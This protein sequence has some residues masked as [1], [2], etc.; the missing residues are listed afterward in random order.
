M[1]ASSRR[2]VNLNDHPSSPSQLQRRTGRNGQQFYGRY[3]H[4]LNEKHP[5]H[6]YGRPAYFASAPEKPM[7]SR[8]VVARALSSFYLQPLAAVKN[9][10]TTSNISPLY[11]PKPQGFFDIQPK[12]PPL[13][14]HFLQTYL[15]LSPKIMKTSPL[16]LHIYQQISPKYQ[17]YLQKHQK[18]M[19]IFPLYLHFTKTSPLY[20][21][22]CCLRIS[23]ELKWQP[24]A[25]L[26]AETYFE[27][28]IIFGSLVA[29]QEDI[30]KITFACSVCF[31]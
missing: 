7:R 2:V 8:S 30:F 27:K 22:F 16:Y 23:D 28:A 4:T 18:L 5:P 1:L 21:H 3:T 29:K 6:T 9:I 20:L 13:Y 31:G 12:T 11:E 10:S 25:V 24:F 26:G 14:L 15:H 19:K 17:K